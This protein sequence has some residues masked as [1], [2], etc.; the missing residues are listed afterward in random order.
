MNL[1]VSILLVQPWFVGKMDVSFRQDSAHSGSP[2]THLQGSVTATPVS[3]AAFPEQFCHFSSVSPDHSSGLCCQEMAIAVNLFLLLLELPFLWTFLCTLALCAP[4]GIKIWVPCWY[5]AM[6]GD[7]SRVSR[8]RLMIYF[9]CK[10]NL[11]FIYT[12]HPDIWSDSNS[13]YQE[14]KLHFDSRVALYQ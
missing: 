8:I 2:V 12:E 10:I 7:F 14:S 9:H 11:Q 1:T 6:Q 5:Q 13:G 4:A 3:S